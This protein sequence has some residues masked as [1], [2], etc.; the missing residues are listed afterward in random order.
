MNEPGDIYTDFSYPTLGLKSQGT[1][2]VHQTIQF[3]P[4][5]TQCSITVRL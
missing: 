4:N 2:T 1:L 3:I 5:E